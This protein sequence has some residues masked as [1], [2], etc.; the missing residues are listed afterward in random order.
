MLIYCDDGHYT[1]GGPEDIAN[2]EKSI[3]LDKLIDNGFWRFWGP[4][5]PIEAVA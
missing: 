2:H 5:N 3:P 4:I 1:Y